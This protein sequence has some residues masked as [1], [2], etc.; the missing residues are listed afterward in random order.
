MDLSACSDPVNIDISEQILY[1][2]WRQAVETCCHK[3]EHDDLRQVSIYNAWG[4]VE[5]QMHAEFT[6]VAPGLERLKAFIDLLLVRAI[7]KVDT[8]VI[9]GMIRLVVKVNASRMKQDEL[10]SLKSA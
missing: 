4:D 8:A 9:R 3:L 7:P 10:E 5:A 1:G 6:A 2:Q